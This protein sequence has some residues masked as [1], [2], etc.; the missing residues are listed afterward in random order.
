MSDLILSLLRTAREQMSAAELH[1]E[2]SVL[3]RTR[4]VDGPKLTE[5]QVS[6]FLSELVAT[7]V[8]NE[9]EPGVYHAA[10]IVDPV[11]SQLCL[12]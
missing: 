7:K 12:F 1:H 5:D 6:G 3:Q 2:Y 9:L 10:L 4:C 8:V 11:S